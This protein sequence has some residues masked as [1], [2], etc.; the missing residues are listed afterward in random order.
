MFGNLKSK[1]IKKKLRRVEESIILLEADIQFHSDV[2]EYER[3]TLSE[4]QI[5][6]YNLTIAKLQADVETSK[7]YIRYISPLV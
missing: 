7:K 2:L 3:E 1:V 6:D 4:K 5:N